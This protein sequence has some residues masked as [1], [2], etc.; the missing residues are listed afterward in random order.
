MIILL[1]NLG[2]GSYQSCRSTLLSSF[3]LGGVVL[4]RVPF[5]SLSTL[6]TYPS[7]T[8]ARYERYTT[9]PNKGTER[10]EVG[11]GPSYTSRSLPILSPSVNRPQGVPSG[12][13]RGW[14]GTDY[15]GSEDPSEEANG[16]S[17]ARNLGSKIDRRDG[18]SVFLPSRPRFPTPTTRL[19]RRNPVPSLH[20]GPG[21][22]RVVERVGIK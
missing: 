19:R 11:K 5:G 14:M 7:E 13:G 15:I 8:G 1:K 21:L 12:H 2:Y 6:S 10:R 3:L 9:G 4:G 17:E 16:M 22:R 20:S 18:F